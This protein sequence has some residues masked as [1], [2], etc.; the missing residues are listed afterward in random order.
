MIYQISSLWSSW[1]WELTP[2]LS[3]CHSLGVGGQLLAWPTPRAGLAINIWNRSSWWTWM[4]E[5]CV[6]KQSNFLLDF[7]SKPPSKILL[8]T[9]KITQ[10][11]RWQKP[12]ATLMMIKTQWRWQDWKPRCWLCIVLAQP[13]QMAIDIWKHW[14]T[15]T[16]LYTCSQLAVLKR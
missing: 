7:S 9:T 4:G 8:M 11:W 5:G 10:R 16:S 12:A 13:A 1:D 2:Y 6:I 14:L 3:S 15:L